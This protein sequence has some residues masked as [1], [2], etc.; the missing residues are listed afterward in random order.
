MPKTPEKRE[1]W[2]QLKIK[3]CFSRKATRCTRAPA[4]AGSEKGFHHLVYCTQ[5][6]PVL[7][8]R[9]FLGLEPVTFQSH[10]NKFTSCAKVTPLL[11][12]LLLLL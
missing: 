6:Y 8:K 7:H 1:A 11:I 5:P 10:D 9:L 3:L 4:Y 12:L 2:K